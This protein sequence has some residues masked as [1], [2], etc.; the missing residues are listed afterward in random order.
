MTIST[1]HKRILGAAI[2]LLVPLVLLLASPDI[3]HEQSWCPF[4]RLLHV[5]CVGCGLTK[6]LVC[7]YR[8]DLPGSLTWHPFG[9]VVFVMA[10]LLLAFSIHD[11]RHGTRWG[12]RLLNHRLLW[13]LLGTML[14]VTYLI[15]LF[16]HFL[17]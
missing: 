3:E 5:P 1:H 14:A 4:L 12:D 16:H 10:L 11:L 7:A 17:H 9:L 15:K 13:P 2:T 6:S 8:G